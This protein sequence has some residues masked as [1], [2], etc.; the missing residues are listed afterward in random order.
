[1]YYQESCSRAIHLAAAADDQYR[2]MDW[3]GEGAL[4]EAVYTEKREVEG[5]SLRMPRFKFTYP[6]RH[7][8]AIAAVQTWVTLKGDWR[9]VF[10]TEPTA[11]KEASL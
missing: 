9:V 7:Y 5:W 6:V 3:S 8:I 2:G 1:M 4:D 10:S 11:E